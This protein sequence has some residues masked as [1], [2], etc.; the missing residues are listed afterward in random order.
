MTRILAALTFC[1][2][3][4]LS[5]AWGQSDTAGSRIRDSLNAVPWKAFQAAVVRNDSGAVAAWVRFPLWVNETR[6]SSRLI[7]DSTQFI[8]EFSRVLPPGMRGFIARLPAESLW[9]SWRGTA[10]PR[11]G[12]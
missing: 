10:T 7:R 12:T 1:L 2:V 3:G 6:S 4:F 9:T 5:S 8:R 11:G